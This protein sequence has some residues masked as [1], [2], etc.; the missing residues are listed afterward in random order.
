MKKLL[1]VMLALAMI[2]TLAACGGSS[3]APSTT[4]SGSGSSSSSSSS[5]NPKTPKAKNVKTSSDKPGTA[6]IRWR[7]NKTFD[8]VEIFQSS[9]GTTFQKAARIMTTN[10]YTRRNLKSGQKYY[11]KIR[12]FKYKGKKKK[13]A[14]MSAAKEVT[15]K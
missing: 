12:A 14:K 3:N 1:A 15:V 6:T 13:N 7:N 9:D 11:Y 4:P 5:T 2:F 8:G 10:K